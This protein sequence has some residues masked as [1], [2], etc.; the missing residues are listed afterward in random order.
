MEIVCEGLTSWESRG[1]VI[2]WHARYNAIFRKMNGAF[3]LQDRLGKDYQKLSSYVHGVP[4]GG[5]PTLNGI[6]PKAITDDEIDKFA[7]SAEEVDY[8]LNL[9]FLSVFHTDIMAL[10]NDDF[11]TIMKGI[12]RQKLRRSGIIIPRL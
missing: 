3:N 7:T 10:G 9:L 12:N 2:D 11:R 5:L 1:T 6:E 4:V 8:N